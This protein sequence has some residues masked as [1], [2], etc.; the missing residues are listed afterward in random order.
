MSD[1]Y[2]PVPELSLLK[3]LE[4]RIGGEN[5]STGFDLTEFGATTGIHTWSDDPEFL[6]SFLSFAAANATG[7]IYAIW[8]VDDRAN[9][10]DLP[11]VVFGDEG[12][13]AVVAR[14][15]RELF[16]QL[17]CDKALYVGDYDAG[18]DDEDDEDDRD[19][20]DDRDAEEQ[21][22]YDRHPEYLAWLEQHFGLAPA[23]DPNALVVAA[24]KELAARFANWVGRFIDDRSFEK[25]FM[26]EIRRLH[27]ETD[28]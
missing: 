6:D 18:F 21:S 17:A 16:Q 13:I 7:S 12:G 5:I 25:N 20:R 1:A 4:D 24:E 9:L 26:R 8:R 14:N 27:T 23:E 11:V 19:D 28:E 10:A 3:E 15:L 22:A 2:S